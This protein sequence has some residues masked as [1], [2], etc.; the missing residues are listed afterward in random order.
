MG[1]SDCGKCSGVITSKIECEELGRYY[2][3]QIEK[4]EKELDYFNKTIEHFK[5]NLEKVRE[6]YREGRFTEE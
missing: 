3:V 6:I 2:K 1:A 4:Y 5:Q